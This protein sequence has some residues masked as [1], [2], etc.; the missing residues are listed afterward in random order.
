[1]TR[2]PNY[3]PF[4]PSSENNQPSARLVET[5]W[6]LR[7]PSGK[8]LDCAI[9]SDAAPGLEVRCGYGEENLLRSQR[10]A[11]ISSARDLAEAWRQ[12]VLAKGGFSDMGAESQ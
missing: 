6:R 1:M 9:Y 5:C 8:A 3:S 2:D 10:T 7:G 12:A 4:A 11:E